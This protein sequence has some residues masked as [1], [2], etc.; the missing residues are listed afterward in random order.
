MLRV[1]LIK[2]RSNKET[3]RGARRELHQRPRLVASDQEAQA[4]LRMD[5]MII[6]GFQWAS[7]LKRALTSEGFIP[8]LSAKRL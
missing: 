6:S 8:N 7:D 3:L 5:L 2:S 1:S 4:S